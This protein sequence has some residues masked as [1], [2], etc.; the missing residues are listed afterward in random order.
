M[1]FCL[2][3]KVEAGDPEKRIL[4][5]RRVSLFPVPCPM[6]GRLQIKAQGAIPMEETTQEYA[7]LQLNQTVLELD[8]SFLPM[9]P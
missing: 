2:D 7:G 3:L 8:R 5:N 6:A 4:Q 9:V 1:F